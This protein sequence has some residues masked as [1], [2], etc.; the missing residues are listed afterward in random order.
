[1]GRIATWHNDH[2]HRDIGTPEALGVSQ[3][4][5]RPDIPKPK[6]DDWRHSFLQ[7]EVLEQVKRQASYP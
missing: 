7:N 2:I 5:P 1:M 4:D 3:K 6:D